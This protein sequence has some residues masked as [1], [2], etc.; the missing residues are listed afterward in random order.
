MV[1]V[2]IFMIVLSARDVGRVCR[3]RMGPKPWPSWPRSI[4]HN[5][6]LNPFVRR[7]EQFCLAVAVYVH[8]QENGFC[9][10]YDD[11]SPLAAE[12]GACANRESSR[13]EA[14]IRTG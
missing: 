7:Q 1:L 14:F 9:A 12:I 3:P 10:C 8:S 2:R 5:G 4:V 6:D 11:F 13:R